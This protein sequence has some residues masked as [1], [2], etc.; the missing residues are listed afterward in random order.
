MNR[1]PQRGF[2]TLVQAAIYAAVIIAVM[3]SIA[4]VIYAWTSYTD[5]LDKRGY[6]RGKAELQPALTKCEGD[7]KAQNEALDAL[8]AAG[9]AKA[10]AAAKALA[11]A[12][13]RAKVWEDNAARLRAVLTA[14][15]K[16]GDKAPESCVEA[17]AEIRKPLK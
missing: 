10:K 2:I 12:S 15:R 13:E 3:G 4:G 6:D 5:G 1:I 14:P 17:W 8:K 9:E 7:L 11:G 16:A